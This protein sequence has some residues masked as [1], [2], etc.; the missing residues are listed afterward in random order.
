MFLKELNVMTRS[1]RRAVIAAGAVFLSHVACATDL[2]GPWTL[3]VQNSQHVLVATL[4]VEFTES[5]ARSCLGGE[6]KKVNVVQATTRDDDFYP[7]S[8]PL[9]YRV[10]DG[11][12]TI[13]RNE[14]CDDYLLL[15]GAMVGPSISGNYFGYGP[16]GTSPRGYFELHRPR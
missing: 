3:S 15:K 14:E 7:I 2:S 13:G 8:E 10:E 12:L 4:E 6:W 16:W 11:H 1:L 5:N 9:S